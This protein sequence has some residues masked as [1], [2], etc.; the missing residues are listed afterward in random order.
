MNESGD[1][2]TKGAAR[3]GW[4]KAAEHEYKGGDTLPSLLIVLCH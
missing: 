4:N 1:G 2:E 3:E